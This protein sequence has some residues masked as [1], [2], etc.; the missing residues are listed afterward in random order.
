MPTVLFVRHDYPNPAGILAGC[1]TRRGWDVEEFTVVPKGGD[2]SAPVRFPVRRQFGAIVALGSDYSVND[3]GVGPWLG[4]E[5]AFLLA[6]HLAGIPVLGICFGSQVL[7][8]ALD[9]HVARLRLPVIGWAE[10]D[11]DEPGV[12]EPGPWFSWRED[13]WTTPPGAR[14]LAANR[15]GP[16]AF[17]I[18]HSLGVAF[19]PEATRLLVAEWLTHDRLGLDGEALIRETA[20]YEEAAAARADRLVGA[21]LGERHRFAERL[22]AAR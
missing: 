10:V 19:H 2:P 6:A 4:K 15:S 16:Q 17:G 13:G 22:P 20:L 3:A 1:F 21:L 9:G 14:V 7:S 5:M 11:T 8:L 18:G 12:I